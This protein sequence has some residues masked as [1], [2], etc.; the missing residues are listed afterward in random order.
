MGVHYSTPDHIADLGGTRR[1]ALFPRR[2]EHG[3][4]GH[5]PHALEVSKPG[6]AASFGGDGG[7]ERVVHGLDV[8]C[9]RKQVAKA[10]RDLEAA[11]AALQRG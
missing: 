3:L 10:R 1:A 2:P 6:V 4:L 11:S 8:A 9:V 7:D 5:T